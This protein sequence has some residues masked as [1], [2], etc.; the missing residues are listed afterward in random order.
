MVDNLILE[1]NGKVMLLAYDQGFEHGPTDFDEKSIDPNYILD[2][3]RSGLFTGVIFQEGVAAKY[4]PSA[5]SGQAWL[6]P[7]I[8]QLNGKTSFQGEEPLSLQLCTVDKAIE[9]GAAA[10]GYTIYVGSEHEEQMLTEFSRIEDEA[11]AKGLV[12]IAWMYP[13]GKKVEG[14]QTTKETLAYAARL[15]M[16]LNADYVKIAYS[17]DV[18]SFKWVVAAAG[19]TKVLVQGG[20]KMDWPELE[21]EVTGALAAGASGIAIGRNVWQDSNPVEISKKLSELVFGN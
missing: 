4:Y 21:A 2:I 20:K 3:A 9:L 10:V 17:G 19:K 14:K 12:V 11:H 15:G 13:R 5:S 16:E 1:R 7:L 18:E 6:P 8:A